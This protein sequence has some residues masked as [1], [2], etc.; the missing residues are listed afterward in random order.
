MYQEK[1]RPPHV[2]YWEK[3][4]PKYRFTI[5][6]NKVEDGLIGVAVPQSTLITYLVLTNLFQLRSRRYFSAHMISH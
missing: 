6:V 5:K 4:D 3:P 1:S 2:G